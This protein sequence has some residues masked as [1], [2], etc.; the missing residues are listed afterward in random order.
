MGVIV[1]DSALADFLN[2]TDLDALLAARHA[3]AAIEAEDETAV[4]SLL[5]AQDD[6]QAVAN[7]LMYPEVAPDDVRVDALARALAA[8]ADDYRA[9]A[10]A[11]GVQHLADLGGLSRADRDA[12]APALL[13]LLAR[14]EEVVANRAHVAVLALTRG[15]SPE[16]LVRAALEGGTLTAEQ[17]ERVRTALAGPLPPL[18]ALPSYAQWSARAH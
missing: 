6:P 3:L 8:P 18:A 14:A 2:S 9:L 17:A 4:T 12:L 7:V 16:P 10:A 11:V 5:A 13:S 1:R 15:A